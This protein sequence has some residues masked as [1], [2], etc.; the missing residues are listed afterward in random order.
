MV[1][2]IGSRGYSQWR[3]GVVGVLLAGRQR[4]AIAGVEDV[5]AALCNT[6][7]HGTLSLSYTVCKYTG[8][9]NIYNNLTVA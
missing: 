2:G 3:M 8:V 4:Q 1:R 6:Q 7:T 5:A 9:T